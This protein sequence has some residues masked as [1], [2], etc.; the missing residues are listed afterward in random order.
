MCW[1][2]WRKNQGE[3]ED[4]DTE[5]EKTE[6]GMT[7]EGE[8]V[9]DDQTDATEDPQSDHEVLEQEP[10]VEPEP[11]PQ[12][13]SPAPEGDLSLGFCTTVESKLYVTRIKTPNFQISCG[14]LLLVFD[15]C[16]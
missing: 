5:D 4:G 11:E 16:W 6:E 3:G 7:T 1:S 8:S 13:P 14:T 10:I 15:V 12:P 2:L 9:A